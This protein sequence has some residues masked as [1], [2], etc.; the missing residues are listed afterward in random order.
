MEKLIITIVAP[1]MAP[2]G[3]FC[4]MFACFNDGH[5]RWLQDG[6]RKLA[7]HG[8]AIEAECPDRRSGSCQ[9]P[10]VMLGNLGYG[11]RHV[12]EAGM[13]RMLIGVLRRRMT[14]QTHTQHEAK[15]HDGGT[16]L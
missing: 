16:R 7:S 4:P 10:W 15:N 6:W 1:D 9:L 11:I 2:Q 8:A 14:H 3:G 13:P 12:G 5:R